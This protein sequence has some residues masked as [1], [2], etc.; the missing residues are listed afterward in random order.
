L[1]WTVFR[2]ILGSWQLYTFTIAWTF[3]SLTSG[4]YIMQFFSLWL[5]AEKRFSV[6]EINNIPTAIGAVNFF[7]M[8]GSGYAAD[9]IGS[10]APV[11]AV[12]G[13]LL[14]FCYIILTIWNVPAGLKMAAYILS[15]CYGCFSPLLAGWVNS[16]CGGD[17]Q[18]RAF[19]L[20]WM[21]SFGK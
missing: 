7:F 16:L 4:S 12:V 17:Q 9:A 15:G 14:T 5:T 6:V 19:T 11:T 20:A 10:R 21:V 13:G 2:R 3:W 8:I 18:L 1:D